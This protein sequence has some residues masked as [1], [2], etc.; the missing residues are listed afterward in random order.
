MSKSKDD[1]EFSNYL[2][3][4]LLSINQTKKVTEKR[5]HE[6]AGTAISEH[7]ALIPK[8]DCVLRSDEQL[9]K[10]AKCVKNMR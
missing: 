6:C 7:I 10:K 2:K 5:K 4:H 1:Y 3:D 8:P 9:A